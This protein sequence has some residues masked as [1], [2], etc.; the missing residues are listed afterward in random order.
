MRRTGKLR[1]LFLSRNPHFQDLLLC[2]EIVRNLQCLVP[3][4]RPLRSAVC[5]SSVRQNPHAREA[6]YKSRGAKRRALRTIYC[7]EMNHRMTRRKLTESFASFLFLVLAVVRGGGW[8][9]GGR[10]RKG[11]AKKLKL[12]H[13][14]ASI[15][16][17][18]HFFNF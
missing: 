18:E 13:E 17:Y 10:S 12:D 3:G 16:R 15:K 4:G 1:F 14:E 5:Q 8:C 9:L 7:S 11:E 2:M 6:R